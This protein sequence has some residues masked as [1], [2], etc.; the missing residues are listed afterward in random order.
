M[1]VSYCR[2]IIPGLKSPGFSAKEDKAIDLLNTYQ[3]PVAW[4]TTPTV[5]AAPPIAASPAFCPASTVPSVVSDIILAGF[6]FETT[7][8]TPEAV[9]FTPPAITSN[10]LSAQLKEDD[11]KTTAATTNAFLTIPSPFFR[12][13]MDRPY[14]PGS[15]AIRYP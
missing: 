14:L 7:L 4:L 1:M 8:F 9:A 3:L 15:S 12:H 5:F 13:F 6:A 10:K 11:N 2:T